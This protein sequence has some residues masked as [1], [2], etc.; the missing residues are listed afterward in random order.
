M[1]ALSPQ[2][3][4]IILAFLLLT[5]WFSLY[6]KVIFPHLAQTGFDGSVITLV[7]L[8]F[9][10]FISIFG[11]HPKITKQGLFLLIAIAGWHLSGFISAYLSDHFYPSIIKQIEY[12]IHCM[13]AYSAWVFLSQTQKQEKM[14]WFL[15]FTFVWIVYYILCAWYINEDTYTFDWVH[16][17]PLFNNIRHLGYLQIA[18]LPFLLLPI[19]K[20]IKHK[21]IVAI[22][23]FSI[24]WASVI[25]SGARSTFLVS[26]LVSCL[27]IWF[28][29][30]KRKSI[31]FVIILS[32]IIGWTIALQF[33]TDSQSMDPYRLL[34]LDSRVEQ[35]DINDASSGRLDIWTGLLTQVWQQNIWNGL[36]PD[37][38]AFIR[39]MINN[40][41]SQAHNTA[42]QLFSGIGVIGII[43]ILYGLFSIIQI[44]TKAKATPIAIIARFSFIGALSASM[45]DGH[46]YHTFSLV[47]L[48]IIL[49]LSFNSATDQQKNE[50]SSLILPIL[51]ICMSAV[52]IFNIQKHWN[53]YIQQ[54][55]P[56]EYQEQ[57]DKVSSYPS[58]YRPLKWIYSE[59]TKPELRKTAI[60][61]GQKYGPRYCNYYLIEFME[62]ETQTSASLNEG[63]LQNCSVTELEATGNQK[64]LKLINKDTK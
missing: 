17:T 2:L 20:D 52:S 32:S 43:F 23:L 12:L 11:R 36:G 33:P 10:I 48:M 14:A 26:I 49:A 60:K 39:P 38:Y 35:G 45:L 47:W 59:Q 9:V 62:S 41:V 16:G 46:F 56:L 42:I 4:K 30:D 24:F 58:Y 8:I 27:L 22:I 19:V 63:L 18:I 13:F 51:I 54:Q 29:Q 28:Y 6:L 44:W 61:F 50:K 31:S 37:A 55:F 5:P 53:T 3:R 34:F 25:W 57:L 40:Q 21:Y 15:V 1:V 7:E 64:V